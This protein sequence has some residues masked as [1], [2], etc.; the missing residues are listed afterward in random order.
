MDD[1]SPNSVTKDVTSQRS[2]RSVE[3]PE[4]FLIQ[5]SAV[6]ALAVNNL[7]RING[8]CRCYVSTNLDIVVRLYRSDWLVDRACVRREGQTVSAY[9]QRAV[10]PV[11]TV[12][13]K[14]FVIGG[15]DES[16][17]SPRLWPGKIGASVCRMRMV[18]G[19][20]AASPTVL[21]ARRSVTESRVRCVFKSQ[22]V[23]PL[24]R[25]QLAKRPLCIVSNRRIWILEQ[26]FQRYA[27]PPEA[28]VTQGYHSIGVNLCIAVPGGRLQRRQQ[29]RARAP[30]RAPAPY[31]RLR[32][33]FCRSAR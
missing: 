3:R 32:E 15:H 17:A 18:S 28:N 6:A 27:T 33:G 7:A 5:W 19:V 29:R 2:S 4:A 12:G 1:W 16:L 23:C 8:R 11:A 9:C 25:I 24:C 20:S 26:G 14:I 31:S 30:A 13:C 10:M 22:T 21:P